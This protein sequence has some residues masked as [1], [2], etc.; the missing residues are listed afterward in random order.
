MRHS[1]YL[2]P[3]VLSQSVTLPGVTDMPPFQYAAFTPPPPR[4]S[5]LR[6]TWTCARPELPVVLSLALPASALR[7]ARLR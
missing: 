6:M 5:D 4:V 7:L 3:G 2:V 1:L